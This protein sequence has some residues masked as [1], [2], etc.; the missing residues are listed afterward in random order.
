MAQ[1]TDQF[2]LFLR[3]DLPAMLTATLAAVSCGLLGNF[4]L[5]RRQ[6]LMGDAISH[7]VLPGLV[8]GFLL[9]G[10]RSTGAMFLGAAAAGVVTAVLIELVRRLGRVEPGAAMGVVFSVLF[11]LGVVL[12]RFAD[13]GN[14]DLDPDC[15]LNGQLEGV[16]WPPPPGEDAGLLSPASLAMLPRELVTLLGVTLVTVLFIAGLFKELRIASFDPALASALG[17]NASL[18]HYVLMVFV[19]GAVVASFEA[20]GSILVIAMLI[21]P[22]ATARLLTDRLSTQIWISAVAALA[23][24]VMGYILAA[25]GPGWLGAGGSLSAAGMIA[26]VSGAMLAGAIVAAPRHGVIARALHR[27]RT[28]LTIAEEDLL[29]L[30]YRASEANAPGTVGEEQARTAIGDGWAAKRAIGRLHRAGL[31][32]R[33]DGSLRATDRGR[34]RARSMVRTHRLW[35][36]YLVREVGLRADHVHGS[37]EHLEHVTDRRMKDAL[38]REAPLLDPHRRPIPPASSE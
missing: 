19:A 5:L 2:G 30:L 34:E 15:V 10:E 38:A 23:A 37:A 32:E 1:G 3:L 35:E 13:A 8:A 12:I 7:A 18:L 36:S 28:V 20:V 11:A 16:F 21:C 25:F 17:F 24:G 22:A 4:L 27:R 26:V 9:S 33:R 14:I 31:I 6:S 29:A